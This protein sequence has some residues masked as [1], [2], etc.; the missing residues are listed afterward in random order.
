MLA[1]TLELK[2]LDTSNAPIENIVHKA[3]D[4]LQ[5]QAYLALVQWKME[6]G[7]KAATYAALVKGLRTCELNQ[8]AG[9]FAKSYHL[10]TI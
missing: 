2:G 1:R 5:E 7:K 6:K 4:N 9:R 8:I 10:V 3:R